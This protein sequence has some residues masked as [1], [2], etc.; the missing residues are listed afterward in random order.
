[1]KKFFNIGVI[2]SNEGNG[3][4]ISFSVMFNGYNPKYLHK[5]CD[6]P[7]IKE[8]LPKFHKNKKTNIIQNAKVNYI[9]TQSKKILTKLQK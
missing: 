9:W 7:L 4:P 1:M 8:Y 3:H 5:Y 2:G 6:Y